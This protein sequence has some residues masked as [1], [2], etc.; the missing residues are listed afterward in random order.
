MLPIRM[1]MGSK[2]IGMRAYLGVK[3]IRAGSVGGGGSEMNRPPSA[4]FYGKGERLGTPYDAE[5][6]FEYDGSPIIGVF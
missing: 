4:R 2:L 3:G 6:V 5:K 1:D